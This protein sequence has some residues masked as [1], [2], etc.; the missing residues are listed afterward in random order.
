MLQARKYKK[1]ERWGNLLH[2]VNLKLTP[3]HMIVFATWATGPFLWESAQAILDPS[4]LA[5]VSAL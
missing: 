1:I 5:P 2:A 3:H 4:D